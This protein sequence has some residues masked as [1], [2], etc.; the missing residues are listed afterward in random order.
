MMSRWEK[1]QRCLSLAVAT[2]FQLSLL[3]QRF[4]HVYAIDPTH[5]PDP[6][7]GCALAFAEALPFGDQTFDLVISNCV[8]EHL[9]D[10]RRGLPR[11][12]ARGQGLQD[13]GP[14]R[15]LPL[16]RF[17]VAGPVR[18]FTAPTPAIS[19]SFALMAASIGHNRLFIR[20]LS[21]SR[22][23]PSSAPLSSASSVFTSC[24]RANGWAATDWT[25]RVFSS[26]KNITPDPTSNSELA[27]MPSRRSAKFYFSRVPMIY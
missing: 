19:Q 14:L 7:V 16:T 6:P 9:N 8:L 13:A 1:T 11:V 27:K 25:V 3:R 15:G 5:T 26:C 12:R 4:A 2:A 21:R 22:M 17:S 23:R 20:S 24:P 10:R 18:P